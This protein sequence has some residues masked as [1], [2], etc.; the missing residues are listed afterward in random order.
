MG[1]ERRKKE[2]LS[3][4][5][6]NDVLDKFHR[7]PVASSC[8]TGKSPTAQLLHSLSDSSTPLPRPI[9]GSYNDYEPTPIH[10][11]STVRQKTSQDPC[12]P[13]S[14]IEYRDSAVTSKS[15][16][17]QPTRASLRGSSTPQP[18]VPT[19]MQK[20]SQDPWLPSRAIEHR[21]SSVTSKSLE[22]QPPRASLRGSSTPPPAVPTVMQKT[23]QDP[24]LPSSAIEY[25]E[26]PVTSKSLE[27]QPTRASLRGSSTPPPASP[28]VMQKTS[29]DPWLPS[30]AIEDR[31]STV[32][33]K[34]LEDQPPRASLLGASNPPPAV[35]TVMQKTIDSWSRP[36]LDDVQ[37]LTP[38]RT[39][40]HS[41][42][43]FNIPITCIGT[44]VSLSSTEIISLTRET[45]AEARARIEASRKNARGSI[46][47]YVNAALPSSFNSL[48]LGS[49]IE[50]PNGTLRMKRLISSLPNAV[51]GKA[52]RLEVWKASFPIT[53]FPIPDTSCLS[54]VAFETPFDLQGNV[55]K[56]VLQRCDRLMIEANFNMATV[57]NNIPH[58]SSSPGMNINLPGVFRLLQ[59]HSSFDYIAKELGITGVTLPTSEVPF[60]SPNRLFQSNHSDLSSSPGNELIKEHLVEEYTKGNVLII[61]E[62]VAINKELKLSNIPQ[63]LLSPVSIVQ[64][65]GKGGQ[66]GKNRVVFDGSREWA[67]SRSFNGISD[68]TF[69]HPMQ[70]GHALKRLIRHVYNMRVS[71]PNVP[72]V[73]WSIDIKSAF[74]LIR[75][76]PEY[77]P[78]LA[79]R[80][81]TF[82][83]LPLVIGF[84]ST[85]APMAFTTLLEALLDIFNNRTTSHAHS[86]VPGH[87]D[88][89]YKQ[90]ST[91]APPGNL[92]KAKEDKYNEGVEELNR[93]YGEAYV[94]DI[95]ACMFLVCGWVL[96]AQRILEG[97]V[98]DILKIPDEHDGSIRY[99]PISNKKEEDMIA[100]SE[101]VF[102]GMIVNV[103]Y[104]Y[105]A[106]T[107]EKAI[108]YTADIDAALSRN[109]NVKFMES[110][111]GKLGS[112]RD[113]V[114]LGN[115]HLYAFMCSLDG[116]LIYKYYH[117][118][119]DDELRYHL[120]WWKRVLS[121]PSTRL[122]YF[123]TLVKIF[124][125]CNII[126]D[127]CESGGGGII[128]FNG[129]VYLFS[130]AFPQDI[131]DR[132]YTTE[133]D[134][135]SKLYIAELE[136]AVG[137]IG[138]LMF[139]SL[140]S[141]DIFEDAAIKLWTDN[142][143][144]LA[145]VNKDRARGLRA[146][147]IINALNDMQEVRERQVSI[148]SSHIPGPENVG[149]DYLSR[150]HLRRWC[151]S[152][153]L[154]F[155][156]RRREGMTR[157]LNYI[158]S[159]LANT[160]ADQNVNLSSCQWAPQTIVEEAQ[161]KIYPLLREVI[162]PR[163]KVNK[164][165]LPRGV[166]GVVKVEKFKLN[167]CK[168]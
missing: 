128:S 95:I 57:L 39:I 151:E 102:I 16:E 143:N 126:T 145:W 31:E 48:E 97:T 38:S 161:A 111:L 19:V 71:Q 23:S 136:L 11:Q 58:L 27:D 77:I 152:E 109:V 159:N 6:Q 84:G 76:H 83:I 3:S 35:S 89:L 24:E 42:H 22:D 167:V 96:S 133:D 14:A 8:P 157:V 91:A 25:R 142:T 44:E 139:S 60:S 132:F 125:N 34:S 28:T 92:M 37:K 158:Q 131:T 1:D 50:L 52:K 88:K 68:K 148:V 20:T 156:G 43:V 116:I 41:Q 144:A 115:Y 64:K 113:C 87:Y 78:L 164:S 134:E 135:K 94:D 54:C 112:L 17:D 55:K 146:S 21:D 154:P 163:R 121:K 56:E 82:I 74:L 70:F 13:S 150:C 147:K 117:V 63:L 73:I 123:K 138:I 127:A 5:K 59:N 168:R 120:L 67:D 30:S 86:E 124:P 79:W 9:N 65:P 69:L 155:M 165:K 10:L 129:L 62:D 166:L 75:L 81:L 108:A 153:K 130:F 4:T 162:Q 110:L 46:A 29:P 53:T 33:S 61:S 12:L 32:T 36:F 100:K 137:V 101:Q 140:V 18:A 72:I 93:C 105:L 160:H 7:F 99:H 26:P 90:S 141:L 2:K 119:I 66:P 106:C 85:V 15:L 40:S 149:A 114:A 45:F 104:L 51:G 47:T 122:R 80:F 107:E 118:R 98:S 49:I 103:Q